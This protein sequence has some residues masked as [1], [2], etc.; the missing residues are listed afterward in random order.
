[1]AAFLQP[2][3]VGEGTTVTVD[4]P[5]LAMWL[6]GQLWLCDPTMKGRDLSVDW[7]GIRY[8]VRL[9]EDGVPVCVEPDPTTPGSVQGEPTSGRRSGEHPGMGTPEWN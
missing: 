2:G 6:P 5:R 4:Q 3:S 9:P 8:S 7:L 1:M